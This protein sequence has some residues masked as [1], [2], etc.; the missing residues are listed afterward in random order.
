MTPELSPA[1]NQPGSK[2]SRKSAALA[3]IAMLALVVAAGFSGWW[4][5]SR[6][7]NPDRTLSITGTATIKAEPD[8]FSFYPSYEFKNTSKDAALATLTAKSEQIITEL[9]KLGVADNKIK[10]NASGYERGIYLPK[11][12]SDGTTYN[13]SLTVN[14]SSKELAQKVQDYLVATAPT[15]AVTPQP[16]FSEAKQKQLEA[17]ARAKAE[18]DARLKA[19][20]SAKNLG[21]KIGKVKSISE[22]GAGIMPAFDLLRQGGNASVS[23]ER[24]PIQPGENNLPYS[25]TVVYFIL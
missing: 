7:Q 10:T 9:K 13:L 18:Q 1:Q 24:L 12:E 11:A 23:S 15:G 20:A 3:V 19:E 5:G 25:V 8:E 22:A 14:V 6:S 16:T 2:T 21:Y 17:D 4:F